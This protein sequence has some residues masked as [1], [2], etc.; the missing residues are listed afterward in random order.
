MFMASAA[1]GGAYAIGLNHLF[2]GLAFMPGAFALVAMG[3]VFGAASRAAFTFI[4]FA[5]EITRDY[6]AVL[7]LM[8]VCV[9]AD[10][11]SLLFMRTS[12]MTEKLARRGLRIHAEYEPDVLQQVSVADVMSKEVATVPAD[13]R[14]SALA[15]AISRRDPQVTVHHGVVIVD[16]HN[17]LA[18]VITRSDVLRAMEDGKADRSVLEA[19][20]TRVVVTYPDESLYDAVATMLRYDVGRLPVVSREDAK[21]VIGYLGRSGV[22]TARFRRLQEET[23]LE[24]GWASRLRGKVADQ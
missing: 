4:I 13:M 18:G 10:G 12:I 9:V 22:F 6:N 5:F 21:D 24:P 17:R 11:I 14:V 16:K 3:A 15:E 8:L 7:P 1:M 23:V 2:P 20:T 19:G